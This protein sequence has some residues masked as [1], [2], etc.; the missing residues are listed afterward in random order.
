LHD[1]DVALFA[2]EGGDE[3]IRQLIAA[4]PL[5][6]QANGTLVLEIGINQSETLIELLSEKKYYDIAAK[7]DYSGM[8][9]FL[10]ARYG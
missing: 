3:L 8:T 6:L 2:G 4:A 5:R 7:N 9:R 10:F 1:P